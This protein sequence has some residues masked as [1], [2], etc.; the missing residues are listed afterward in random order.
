[1]DSDDVFVTDRCSCAC[2][3]L[4]SVADNCPIVFFRCINKSDG[5]LIGTFFENQISLNFRSFVN[6]GTPG[7]CLPVVRTDC[8]MKI[9]YSADLRGFEGL[10]Y[11]ELILKYGP[12]YLSTLIL[13]KYCTEENLSRLSTKKAI[14][15]RGFVI[16]KGYL[17][18]LTRF[19]FKLRGSLVKI[20]FKVLYHILNWLVYFA[21]SKITS[22]K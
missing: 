9:P 4:E 11:S 7:E 15:R 14:K 13:R 22:V 17:R 19:G 5:K 10:T 1:M 20:I 18:Y 21:F 3:V 12:A 8:L 16:A 2:E 6:K